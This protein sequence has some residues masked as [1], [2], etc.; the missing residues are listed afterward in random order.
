MLA[1]GQIVDIIG[2]SAWTISEVDNT[3]Q[4][5][6]KLKHDFPALLN[7]NFALAVNKHVVHHNTILNFDDTVAILPPFSG[8]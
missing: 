7:I 4:L 8:G 5:K 1:F 3:D 6:L 2:N